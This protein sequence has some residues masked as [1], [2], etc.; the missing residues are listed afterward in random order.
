MNKKLLFIALTAVVNMAMIT[1][2]AAQAS[3]AFPAGALGCADCHRGS[4]KRDFYPGILEAFP[5]DQS[6]SV[7]EKIVAIHAL[8]NE[9]RAPGLAAIKALLNPPA[10]SP[11]TNP[12][13]HP[14]NKQWDVTVGEA[15]LEIPVYVSDEEDDA[16]NT[17]GNGLTVS[18]VTVDNATG[19]SKFTLSWSPTE[20]QAG[21]TY[22]V[23]IFV[24]ESERS[25]GRILV[26]N[27]KVVKV[28][29]WPARANAETAQV[30]QFALQSAKWKNNKLDMKGLVMFKEGVTAAQKATALANLT[31]SLTTDKKGV[32]VGTPLPLTLNKKGNWSVSIPMD[33]NQVPCSVVAD[34]EGL[35]ASRNVIAAPRKTCLK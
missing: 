12:V 33:A 1:D 29:V 27:S 4:G 13:V 7:A 30:G 11:D 31:M 35:K 20:T 25:A 23:K 32:S 21:Q 28:R 18:P 14:I 16:F 8:T 5:V 26:S 17:L 24:K 15:P 22:P 2:A 3:Y 9:E 10:T 19:L 34:Y 6:L